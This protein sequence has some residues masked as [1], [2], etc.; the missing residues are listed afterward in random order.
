MLTTVT[1]TALLLGL[2]EPDNEPAWRQFCTRYEPML[3][4]VVR[5]AGLS[6]SDAHDVVQETLLAF[7][8]A[9]RAGKFDR[10][11]GRLRSWLRGIAINELRAYWAR[12]RRREAQLATSPSGANPADQIPDEHTLSDI[13]HREWERGVLAAC[14][15][16]VRQEVDAVTFAAFELYAL[17]GRPA[18]EVAAQLRV[19]KNVVYISKTRVLARVRQLEAVMQDTW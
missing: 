11:R 15:D 9:F 8:Q 6:D 14:L 17:E 7:V 12:A 2:R 4:A 1:S 18:E 19:T 5:Q 16:E 13:F 10:E 3:L